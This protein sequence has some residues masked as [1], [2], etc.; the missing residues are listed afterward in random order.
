VVVFVDEDA[1]VVVRV[2]VVFDEMDTEHA[3]GG[4][5]AVLFVLVASDMNALDLLA[6]S[7][8]EGVHISPLA[9][10]VATSCRLR[11]HRCCCCTGQGQEEDGWCG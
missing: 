6:C 9:E 8:K 1:A 10:T 5:W 3:L 2:I 7:E 4:P 11:D